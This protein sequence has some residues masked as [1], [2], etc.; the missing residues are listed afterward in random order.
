M[1]NLRDLHASAPTGGHT[2]MSTRL[3][4]ALAVGF[5]CAAVMMVANENAYKQTTR[6]LTDV[7]HAHDLHIAVG[8]TLLELAQA[9]AA[10]RGYVLTGDSAYLDSYGTAKQQLKGLLAS[11]DDAPA[12]H[13][14]TIQEQARAFSQAVL[15][16]FGEMDLTVRLRQQDRF[17]AAHFVVTTNVGLD[18]MQHA[19]E[20]AALLTRTA[21]ARVDNER[22]EVARLLNVTRFGLA[23]GI[24]AALLA[25]VLYTQQTRLLQRKEEDIKRALEAER[26]ALE[27]QVQERTARLTELATHL[28]QA[29]EDERAH[30]ARELHD[31]LG[32]LLT[33][34]KLDVA[35]LKPRLPANAPELA[36]RLTHLTSILNQG[37]ALKRRIIEDL[38]PSSLSNLGLVAS[39]Q[40]LAR[41]FGERSRIE[42][43]TA[44]EPVDLDEA[45]EL[46][47]Y[48]M[49]QESLTNIGKYAKASH[50]SVTLKNYV[51]HAEVT[52][53]DNGIGFD[54]RS[55]PRAT[56]G[57][58]GM[59]HRIQACGG[60]LDINS[61][62]GQGT[63]ITA[64]IPRSQPKPQSAMADAMAG[65]SL[66][67]DSYAP[68]DPPPTP[69]G[70][71]G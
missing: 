27:S 24:L 71:P 20:L 62:P 19:R 11:I 10:Q 67:A 33:A 64:T 56:H 39:L 7:R 59:R 50:V 34:A 17:D 4:I 12:L 31:E 58:M 23:A 21:Q 5:V 43:E 36:E 60:R 18:Q 69:P 29:V 30:L 16:R 22:A 70:A 51:Y 41:E 40:I 65:M 2:R 55:L 42:L 61:T 44:L 25:F 49:V 63:R 1:P 8:S 37:I 68:A 47:I 32:A 9:E 46:T 52:V 14:K 66:S 54:P 3:R 15:Q 57:L 26:D 53:A 48:R 28:Q 6:A 35:R 38:R 13:D 45:R